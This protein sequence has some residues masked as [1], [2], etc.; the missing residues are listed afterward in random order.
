MSTVVS[1][2]GRVHPKS[3]TKN[4]I[5]CIFGLLREAFAESA[6]RKPNIYTI[7]CVTADGVVYWNDCLNILYSRVNCR[8]G[9]SQTFFFLFYFTLEFFY[10]NGDL[11]F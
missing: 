2:V 10:V 3:V 9:T 5:S 8:I 1:K 4:S 11:R 6:M 7:L